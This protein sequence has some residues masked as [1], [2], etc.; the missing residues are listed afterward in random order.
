M[1]KRTCI[2]DCRYSFPFNKSGCKKNQH[3]LFCEEMNKDKKDIKNKNCLDCK[4]YKITEGCEF[5]YY[6]HECA[7]W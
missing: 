2:E 6:A 1:K 4:Y 7:I 5:D 3:I